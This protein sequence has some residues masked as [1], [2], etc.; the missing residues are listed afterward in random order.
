MN[1]IMD[2]SHSN[3]SAAIPVAMH[4]C[5]GGNGHLLPSLC[6]PHLEHSQHGHRRGADNP[7]CRFTARRTSTAIRPKSIGATSIGYFEYALDY[8]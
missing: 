3:I 1:Q 6:P 8:S 5:D 2:Q 4:T 7:R